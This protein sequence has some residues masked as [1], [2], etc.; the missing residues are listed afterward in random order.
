MARAITTKRI[1]WLY[2]FEIK[3]TKIS[4]RLSEFIFI[5]G[6]LIERNIRFHL[7]PFSQLNHI[8]DALPTTWSSGTN[9]QKRLSREL[10][11]LSPI[12]Q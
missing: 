4:Q 2:L 5:A 1:L 9:P 7:G 12:I 11:R 10:C 8:K 3:I 6:Y